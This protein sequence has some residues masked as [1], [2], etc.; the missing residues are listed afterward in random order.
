MSNELIA[1]LLGCEIGGLS[2]YFLI[3]FIEYLGERKYRREK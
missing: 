2:F 1:F 3:L